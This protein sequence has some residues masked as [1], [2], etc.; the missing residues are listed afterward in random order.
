M[1]V[2]V[3]NRKPAD[4][5]VELATRAGIGLFTSDLDTWALAKKLAQLGF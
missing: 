3:K 2:I 5:V 1:V 4:D